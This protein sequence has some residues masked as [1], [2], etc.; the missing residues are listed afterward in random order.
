MPAA[1]GRAASRT[2][3]ICAIVRGCAASWTL[4]C[5]A[6][7]WAGRPDAPAAATGVT[8]AGLYV[9]GM[10]GPLAFGAIAE[11]VGFSAAWTAAAASLGVAAVM[12]FVGR[13]VL[14]HGLRARPELVS[15][16]RG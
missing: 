9:G 12:T 16:G 1:A 4:G 15:S 10:L 7:G 6:M 8:Q 11:R 14:A 5:I 2:A 13:R 3:C